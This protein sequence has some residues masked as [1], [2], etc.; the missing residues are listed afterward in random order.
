[1]VNSS[2]SH[3]WGCG[4]QNENSQRHAEE[5]EDK[6]CK[7]DPSCNNL[8]IAHDITA[9]YKMKRKSPETRFVHV[10]QRRNTSL[11]VD[12]LRED[13][14]VDLQCMPHEDS[15]FVRKDKKQGKKGGPVAVKPQGS[16]GGLPDVGALCI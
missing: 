1:M 5:L 4:G 15:R 7:H 6:K 16:D 8:E 3:F 11:V 14:L 2:L 10:A 13:L 9:R 12:Q